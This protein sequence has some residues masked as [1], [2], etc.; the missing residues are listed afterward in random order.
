MQYVCTSTDV[1]IDV[2]EFIFPLILKIV[3]KYFILTLV[4]DHGV[5]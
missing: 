2:R 1:S 5:E 4:I 3:L